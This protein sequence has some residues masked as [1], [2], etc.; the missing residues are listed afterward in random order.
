VNKISDQNKAPY[1]A[2]Q[3]ERYGNVRDLTQLAVTNNTNDA[4][5]HGQGR[6]H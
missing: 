3:L 6:S 4:D 2:P 5:H 1:N